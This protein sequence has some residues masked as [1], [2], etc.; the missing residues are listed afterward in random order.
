MRIRLTEKKMIADNV[1]KLKLE[2]PNLKTF[3]PGAHIGLQTPFGLKKYSLISHPKE[4]N[5]Y[6]VAVLRLDGGIGGSKW[7][8]EELNVEDLI[9]VEGPFQSFDLVENDGPQI[10]LAGGIGITPIFSFI[11]EFAEHNKAFELH[12]GFRNNIRAALKEEILTLSQGRSFFYNAEDGENLVIDK[13]VPMYSSGANVYVCGPRG[14]IEAVREVAKVKGWPASAVHFESFGTGHARVNNQATIS[15]LLS[16]LV[17]TL[18]PQ[19]SVLDAL[20]KAGAWV[21]YECKRGECGKCVL[22]YSGGEVEH[23]DV[24]LS[25]E[26]RKTMMCPCVSRPR[27]SELKLIV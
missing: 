5:F 18:Q 17:V 7:L 9:E 25:P 27:G 13:I 11:R 8:H 19:E 24:C 26:S 21:S 20:E 15:L 6:E 16:D 12:Y 22:E 4:L 1:C 23:Q 2:G 3:R 10:F 14:M